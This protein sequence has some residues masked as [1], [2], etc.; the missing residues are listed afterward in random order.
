MA[1]KDRIGYLFLHIISFGS[2]QLD[3]FFMGGYLLVVSR[4]LWGWG[5]IRVPFIFMTRLITMA[6]PNVSGRVNLAFLILSFWILYRPPMAYAGVGVMRI[7]C[8]LYLYITCIYF[9]RRLCT[10]CGGSFHLSLTFIMRYWQ[11]TWSSYCLKG[12]L[13]ICFDGY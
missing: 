10:S 6:L 13:V 12:A 1:Q 5:L 9:P 7:E 8:R 11:S 2:F 3:G 4:C